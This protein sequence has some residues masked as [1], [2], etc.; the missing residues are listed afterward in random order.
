MRSAHGAAEL[1][2][3]SNMAEEHAKPTSGNCRF[4]RAIEE[5]EIDRQTARGRQGAA[6]GIGRYLRA[7]RSPQTALRGTVAASRGARRE[8]HA[9]RRRQADRHRTAGRRI[10]GAGADSGGPIRTGPAY[11]PANGPQPDGPR[12]DG[13]RPDRPQQD[14]AIRT[15]QK[16]A[17]IA[18]CIRY[19][20]WRLRILRPRGP[21]TM[22]KAW[23]A[24]LGA[25]GGVALTFAATGA[26]RRP[27][28]APQPKPFRMAK[29]S[30][31]LG[32]FAGAFEQVRSHGVERPDESQLVTSAIGGMLANLENSYYLDAKTAAQQ[33]ACTA[34]ACGNASG[35]IGVTIAMLDGLATIATVIDQLPAAKAGILAGDIIAAI[36]NMSVDGLGYFQITEKLRGSSRHTGPPGDRP[37][38]PHQAHHAC[39]G[40]RQHPTKPG[41][42]P[43]GRRRYRLHSHRHVHRQHGRAIAKGDRRHRGS[44]RAR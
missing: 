3:E 39:V 5:L 37:P 28:P 25:V 12:Q 32:L 44:S 13:P 33:T 8:N 10:A 9:R 18:C 16:K 23:F 21:L 19:G 4:E 41:P 7:R 30:R 36:D 14:G 38:R 42:L 6:R 27:R 31:L 43:S 29:D 22:H 40:Q 34:A 2:R 15:A 35:G 20:A 11:A 24:L 17:K 26:A 1:I